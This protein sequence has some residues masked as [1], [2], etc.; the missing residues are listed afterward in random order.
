MPDSNLTNVFSLFSL[1]TAA[2]SVRFDTVIYDTYDYLDTVVSFS[3][4][5]VFSAAFKIYNESS[6]DIR[7]LKMMEL[8]RYGSNDPVVVL[9]IRYGF[10]PED[11]HP[12]LPFVESISESNIEFK[13]EV[14]TAPEHLQSMIKWYL[15]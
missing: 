9:L 10:P 3:L 1:E 5:E 6:N 14:Q 12:L 4:S 7:A 11:V 15:P 8:L 13:D 2:S